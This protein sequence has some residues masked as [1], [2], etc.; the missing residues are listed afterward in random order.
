MPRPLV[1]ALLCTVFT[2]YFTIT[3]AAAPLKLAIFVMTKDDMS[4]LPQWLVYHIHV[5]GSQ[6]I[7]VFDGSTGTQKGYLQRAA[8]VS[9]F[10]LKQSSANLNQILPLLA[11]WMDSVKHEFDWM[12]KVDTDEFLAYAQG[13]MKKPE[14]RGYLLPPPEESPRALSVNVQ[15]LAAPVEEGRLPTESTDAATDKYIVIQPR[16][17]KQIYN[18]RRYVP[19]DLNLGSH[20]NLFKDMPIAKGT[21]TVHY[22]MRTYSDMV[23]MARQ[24]IISHGYINEDDE[25]DTVIQKLEALDKRP[26]CGMISCHKNWIVLDD[27]KKGDAMRAQYYKENENYPP[28]LVD[29]RDRLYEIFGNYSVM[30]WWPAGTR[31]SC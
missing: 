23:R 12:T 7:F 3:I 8:K 19:S 20:A 6:S 9:G 15:Y 30:P 13:D 2:I 29:F 18:C 22:H 24:V 4:L 31:P 25:R 1:T 16:R 28:A 27:L 5:Y 14:A 17:Y 10:N 11:G 26:V 21:A